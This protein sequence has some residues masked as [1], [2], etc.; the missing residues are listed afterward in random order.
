M[1][2]ILPAWHAA[3]PGVGTSVNAWMMSDGSGRFVLEFS[4]VP[5]GLYA[6]EYV[7]DLSESDWIQVPLRLKA[8]ANRTQWIDS[9]PPATLP[10]K[11]GKRFYRVKQIEY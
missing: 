9:G 1:Q 6:V 3:L 10:V 2:Y 4:S 5:G 7:N 8:G 11:A